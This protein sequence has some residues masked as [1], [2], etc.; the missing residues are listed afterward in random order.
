MLLLRGAFRLSPATEYHLKLK[1]DQLFPHIV[2]RGIELAEQ[3]PAELFAEEWDPQAI[4]S[5]HPLIYSAL[6]CAAAYRQKQGAVIVCPTQLPSHSTVVALAWK[7]VD[8]KP[9]SPE[10]W[11]YISFFPTGQK[12]LDMLRALYE[13]H[14]RE[15]HPFVKNLDFGAFAGPTSAQDLV[16][17]FAAD[18]AQALL[19]GAQLG[20][21]QLSMD[22]AGTSQYASRLAQ[23]IIRPSEREYVSGRPHS[24]TDEESSLGAVV[25]VVEIRYPW[26][27]ELVDMRNILPHCNLP[28]VSKHFYLQ[29]LLEVKSKDAAMKDARTRKE[30]AVKPKCRVGDFVQFEDLQGVSLVIGWEGVYSKKEAA[31]QL[32]QLYDSDVALST[33]LSDLSLGEGETGDMRFIYHLLDSL[34]G[35]SAIM[36]TSHLQRRNGVSGEN[37]ETALKL[38]DIG[39]YFKRVD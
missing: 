24:V 29:K 22:D 16:H 35:H 31:E 15:N 23:L 36:D 38:Y 37:V 33:V 34:G 12:N 14:R 30:L 9:V 1:T 27:A 8:G 10:D 7:P 32:E 6:F 17:L 2:L 20:Y 18:I 25:G 39:K 19:R 4:S 28:L 21:H 26:D 3:E 5:G 13:H 11:T